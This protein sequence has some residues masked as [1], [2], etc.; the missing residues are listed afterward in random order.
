MSATASGRAPH[1]RAPYA[2]GRA[3][4]AEIL[5]G[6]LRLLARD[7]YGG[8]SM[9]RIAAE[10][11]L[12]P[13]GLSR[14]FAG[15][16][17][18]LAAL[19]QRLVDETET[20]MERHRVDVADPD[21]LLRLARF[22]DSRPGYAALFSSLAGAASDSGH[23]AHPVFRR[24]YDLLPGALR[25]AM[26]RL[27][28]PTGRADRAADE[29]VRVVAAWDGLQLQSQYEPAISVPTELACHFALLRGEPAV[30]RVSA[31]PPL[32]RSRYLDA[33]REDDTGYLPGRERRAEI[34]DMALQLFARDGYHAVSLKQ[35]ASRTGIPKSSV[36]YH[37][38]TKDALLQAVL[39]HRDATTIVSPSTPAGSPRQELLS[40]VDGAARNAA[41]LG[42][43]S[44]YA[45]LSCEGAVPGHPAH[46]YFVRRMR[47]VRGYFAALF[48]RIAD[49]DGL[50]PGRDPEHEAI[51]LI[52]LWDGLQLQWLYSPERVDIPGHLHAHLTSLLTRP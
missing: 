35:I 39:A 36:L 21:D 7:G 20:W 49:A 28:T 42:M 38:P 52:A 50:A 26:A 41:T 33:T 19:L 14:H 30:H 4:R 9:R 5:T 29:A 24:Q 22:N 23:P 16:D 34:V 45:G 31:G 48:R 40:L 12:T 11:G 6:T 46:P 32:S 10:S 18:I 37:F 44:T 2:N 15:K 51:W 1:T 13:P 3:R 25:E 8:L 27:L 17:Q 43:V 47:R